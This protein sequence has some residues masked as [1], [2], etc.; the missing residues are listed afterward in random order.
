M[1]IKRKNLMQKK[2]KS[3]DNQEEEKKEIKAK[4]FEKLFTYS[5]EKT[6]GMNISS[7]DIN[8]F[9]PDLIVSTYGRFEVE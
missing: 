2:K 8:P 1:G 9:N 4:R 7:M 5:C 3:D 6:K